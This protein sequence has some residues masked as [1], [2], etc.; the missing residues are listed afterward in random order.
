MPYFSRMYKTL[1]PVNREPRGNA[2]GLLTDAFIKPNCT[3]RHINQAPFEISV[4]QARLPI[5]TNDIIC[6]DRGHPVDAGHRKR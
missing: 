4:T 6:V 2:G 3:C 1:V 5:N